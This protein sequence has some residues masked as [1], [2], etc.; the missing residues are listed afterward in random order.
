MLLLTHISTQIHLLQNDVASLWIRPKFFWEEAD[1][2]PFFPACDSLAAGEKWMF[3]AVVGVY[4][5]IT[6]LGFAFFWM[7][8]SSRFYAVLLVLFLVK[9]ALVA[10]RYAFFGNEELLYLLLSFSFL[11]LPGKIVVG[12]WLVVL[13]HVFAGWSM[14]NTEWLS[15]AALPARFAFP[16]PLLRFV[17]YEIA[18]FQALLIWGVFSS[19]ALFR[20][21]VLVH[22]IALSFLSYPVSGFYPFFLSLAC[23]LFLVMTV[24]RDGVPGGISCDFSRLTGSK[25]RVV[26]LVLFAV[27]QVFPRWISEDAALSGLPKLFAINVLGPSLQCHYHLFREKPGSTEDLRILSWGRTD[28]TLCD[29]LVFLERL[30]KYCLSA[31]GEEKNHFVLLSK[32]TTDIRARVILKIEDACQKRNL[33]W[34]ELKTSLGSY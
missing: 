14:L 28:R 4:A 31:T 27:A 8:K 1:C 16:Q 12:R 33:Q 11:F 19:G 17:L 7:K 30:R 22:L 20:K 32:R 29:P 2:W 34:F 9:A 18:L 10:S 13:F 6:F 5:L 15:G 24:W 26:F 21:A 25:A 3:F 23:A